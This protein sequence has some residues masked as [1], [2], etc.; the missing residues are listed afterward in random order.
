[1]E[2]LILGGVFALGTI[3]TVWGYVRAFRT[4][5][6]VRDAAQAPGRIFGIR[7]YTHE[8]RQLLLPAVRFETPEGRTVEFTSEFHK[9]GAE[10][11][12][13]VTVLYDPL[14]PEKAEI[15][16]SW[17]LVGTPVA[18]IAAGMFCYGLLGLFLYLVATD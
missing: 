15:K 5:R 8:H 12:Q 10:V 13:E 6:F 1:M 7:H 14:R 16:G 9:R 4:W 3:F 11:G 2:S 18:L 17:G